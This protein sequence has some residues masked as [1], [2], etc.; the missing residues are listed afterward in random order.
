MTGKFYRLL[1]TTLIT[2][3]LLLSLLVLT[4]GS[5]VAWAGIEQTEESINSSNAVKRFQIM[6]TPTPIEASLDDND[7]SEEHRNTLGEGLSMLDVQ[8][9]LDGKESLDSEN[10]TYI[11]RIGG[12]IVGFDLIDSHRALV[13]EGAGFTVL[14]ISS[15]MTPTVLARSP[16]MPASVRDV[17]RLD[18]LALVADGWAG[19]FIWDISN[20]LH[21]IKAG[22][23]DISAYQIAISNNLAYVASGRQGMTIVDISDPEHPAALG[24]FRPD[25]PDG[26][27]IT[28]IIVRNSIAY[29]LDW[30]HGLWI[31]DVQ[32]PAEPISLG[33]V[34]ISAAHFDLV[35]D[36][37]FLGY[38]STLKI[39]NI[40]N[41]AQPQLIG[42]YSVVQEE[43]TSVLVSGQYAYW[44][45]WQRLHILDI[46]D[47]TSP[48]EEAN[49][50]Y[51]GV[52]DSVFYLDDKLY[53]S[54]RA[55]GLNVIDISDATNPEVTG[56]Y[57]PPGGV[58]DVA[59]SGH[60]AYLADCYSVYGVEGLRVV[61]ITHAK[62]PQKTG[63]LSALDPVAIGV[64]DNVAYLSIWSGDFT[65]IDISDPQN[66]DWLSGVSTGNKAIGFDIAGGYAYVASGGSGLKIIDISEPTHLQLVG[67]INPGNGAAVDVAL[68][69]NYAYLAYGYAGFSHYTG[70]YI[71]D[72]ADKTH[73]IVV[74]N[75]PTGEVNDIE[76][77]GDYLYA[78][79]SDGLHIFNISD[80]TALREVGHFDARGSD[81]VSIDGHFLYVGAKY[82]GVYILDVTNPAQPHEVGHYELPQGVT[83]VRG[84][85]GIIYATLSTGHGAGG[86]VILQLTPLPKLTVSP[87]TVPAD[88]MAQATVVLKNAPTGHRVRFIV[89]GIGVSHNPVVST[90]D[91]S[92][93]ATTTIRSKFPGNALI[94]A[95]DLT[96]GRTFATSATVT[97]TSVVGQTPPPPGKTGDIVITD[98]QGICHSIDCPKDGFFMLG[99]DN[100]ALRLKVTADWKGHPP[101]Q[102]SYEVNQCQEANLTTENEAQL[103]INLNACLHEGPN[104][105]RILAKSGEAVSQPYELQLYGYRPP[106]WILQGVSSLPSI[107]NQKLVL[108]VSFPGQP[109]GKNHSVDWGFPGDLNRFQ[110]QTSIKMTLPTQGGDFEVEISR[111]RYHAKRGRPAKA[112]LYLLGRKADLGYK[113]TLHGTLV[114]DPPYVLVQ[115][116]EF[117]IS[118]DSDLAEKKL[119]IPDALYALPPLGPA[120][121]AALYAVPPIRNWLNDR[122][123]LYIKVSV[124]LTGKLVFEFQPNAR[125]S[126]VTGT[127]DFPIEAGAKVDLWVVEGKIYAG[128]GG[129]LRLGYEAD[130][131]RIASIRAYG[132]G[133]YKFRVGWFDIEDEGKMKLAEYPPE[134]GQLMLIYESASDQVPTWHLIAH[135]QSPPE[136]YARYH[137]PTPERP[138]PFSQE[139]LVR[140]VKGLPA[141][142]PG[143]LAATVD[144]VLVSNVYT[145]TEPALAL[146]PANDHVLLAWVHDDPSKQIGQS[147][148]IAYSYWD[149]TTW[150]APGRITDDTYPDVAPTLAWDGAGHGLALWQRLDD[151]NLPITATLDVTTTSKIEI[152]WSQYDPATDSWTS[153]AWLTRNSVLDQTPAAAANAQGDVLAVWRQNPANLLSGDASH[154]DRIMVAFWNGT[155][156]DA[157]TV[158]VEGI[159]GLVELAAG[160][161]DNVATIAYTQYMTP[162]GGITPTL[163]LFTSGWDGGAW[164]APQQLTDDDQGHR[165]PAVVYNNQ[166]HPWLVWQAGPT[167]R[168][169]DLTT[170]AQADL[171]LPE[172][173]EIDEFRVLHDADDNLAAVFTAQDEGQRDLFVAFYDAAHNV[174]GAPIPLTQ[175][176]DSEGY[177]APALD[178]SGR[179]LMAYARTEV[180]SEQRTT[181]D[182]ATGEPITYTLPVEG[183]TDL[184]TLSHQF[185]RDAAAGNLTL[186]ETHPAPGA[187]VTMTATITNTGDLP[188]P[189]LQVG[190]YDG[191]PA[192]G[193]TLLDTSTIPGLLAAGYTATVTATLTAPASS[194]PHILAVMADPQNQIDEINEA[195]NVSLLSAFG[196][197]LALIDAAAIPWGGS[198]VGLK[199]VVQN[200][201]PG[202][203]PAATI[204]YHWDA[205]TGTL[206]ITDTI[207]PLSAGETYTQ[208]TPWD[209]GALPEG[210]HPLAAAVNP[211]QS[212]FPE[213]ELGNNSREFSLES[214]PDLA[215]SPYYFWADSLP[216]G[217]VAITLTVSNN[218]SVASRETSVNLYLDQPFTDTARIG[219]LTVPA[220]QPGEA[221]MLSYQWTPRGYAGGDLYAAVNED[222]TVGEWSWANNLASVNLPVSTQSITLSGGWTLMSFNR[223]TASAAVTEV[224]ASVEGSYDR[225][226]G[227]DGSYVTTLPPGFNTLKEMSPGKA[228]WV[229]ATS[230]VTLTLTGSP[231]PVNTSIELHTG[232]NW[233]GYLPEASQSV[234]QA[235]TSIEGK[236]TWV[237]GDDGSFVPSLPVTFNTLKTMEPGK[238]YLIYM[239]QAATLTY[240]GP[241]VAQRA[242]PPH[243]LSDVALCPDLA[244]TPWF[245]EIYG[246]FNPAAAGQVLRAVDGDDRV[247]GCARVRANGSYGLM[248][249][250]GGEDGL[251]GLRFQLGEAV[252]PAPPA[253]RWSPGH[254]LMRLDFDDIPLPG[255]G[256]HRVWLP[257]VGR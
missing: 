114:K 73:P 215:V 161:G 256:G 186:S 131:A 32:N 64:R 116:L 189:N 144:D 29:V 250:Y 106:D 12:Y 196:P 241:A 235:L 135:I 130:D 1:F 216:D 28:Q 59:V 52:A 141:L 211:D 93:Q 36:N 97:F 226:L 81:D 155:G 209:F 174:W 205:I 23:L 76:I 127:A 154:P 63:E 70:I 75:V 122:A 15:R 168:L 145:Y 136:R 126:E 191:D 80:P 18:D 109:L 85:G 213:L 190:F 129:K 24:I 179:L 160:Y 94:T 45:T 86:L 21:P 55:G 38:G 60:H 164:S 90:I 240:P 66:P 234:T 232:W 58:C 65:A 107:D 233:V 3:V 8:M 253:F 151:P 7:A 247:V 87:S 5:D 113:G 120:A 104:T 9:A 214:L 152:A 30:S 236:Y 20:P 206:I 35:G 84:I 33:L 212:D 170:G 61:D 246:Q 102:I 103:E 225:I 95:R 111:Q 208:T 67:E 128:L 79:T 237:I 199:A 14:D 194:T 133:G 184:V 137:A 138:A 48:V 117:E 89:E 43:S 72:I 123:N 167:L 108:E 195:N 47:P 98:V 176:R 77:G 173:M 200:L 187:T 121:N 188:L 219:A 182:P 11:G 22:Y 88:G 192:A 162:T 96:S 204:A 2:T 49:I 159:P 31:V 203:S 221:T 223:I 16:L 57:D 257:L 207:P 101:G 17:V 197:D 142:T 248:R 156:W 74:D 201:G 163:Q 42:S 37:A 115:K 25:T 202:E 82:Y 157:P 224:M 44:F 146:N 153:P 119:G 178:S 180:H 27:S 165:H 139:A 166:N 181:T 54:S 26:L 50:Y 251:T 105:L 193:G 210:E 222:R 249:L 62:L 242:S 99:L 171:V 78:A 238:G 4:T 229:H 41:P 243:P 71:I 68:S 100:L 230:P 198:D 118:L 51:P 56:S 220:L 46:S 125:L 91:A 13:G 134:S 150:R 110:W 175:D 239:T 227:E 255:S 254:E 92:G 112:Q 140:K 218:G 34:D 169:R 245:S 158:A 6:P 39:I 10:I 53:V 185:V 149:G 228:Y 132:Y 143:A 244:R 217:R 83:N 172:G 183:Q 69:G 124:S 177:P 40:T 252:L 19:F 147:T 148:E 231:M